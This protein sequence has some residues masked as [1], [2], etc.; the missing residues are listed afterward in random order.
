MNRNFNFSFQ[1]PK[2]KNQI[3]K[4]LKDYQSTQIQSSQFLKILNMMILKQEKCKSELINLKD[5]TL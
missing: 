5:V 3:T 2:Q 4:L 1:E